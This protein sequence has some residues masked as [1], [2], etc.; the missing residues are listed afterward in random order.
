MTFLLL[1]GMIHDSSECIA[2][3]TVVRVVEGSRHRAGK[4]K[5]KWKRVMTLIDGSP[6]ITYF[7]EAFIVLNCVGVPSSVFS[8]ALA[9]IHMF[10]ACQFNDKVDISFCLLSID[11]NTTL[12]NL[13]SHIEGLVHFHVEIYVLIFDI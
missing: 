10:L 1:C 6:E 7:E 2:N 5:R 11:V 3:V 4:Q 13:A 8:R 12:D 9:P